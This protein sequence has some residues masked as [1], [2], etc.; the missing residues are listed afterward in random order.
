M[1]SRTLLIYSTWRDMYLESLYDDL[2]G[3]QA[4]SISNAS[5]IIGYAGESI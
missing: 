1:R 3:V 5:A 2:V 4:H